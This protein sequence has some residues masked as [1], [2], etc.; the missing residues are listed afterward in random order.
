M[1][2]HNSEECDPYKLCAVIDRAYRQTVSPYFPSVRSFF[3]FAANAVKPVRETQRTESDKCGEHV[4]WSSVG[5]RPAI[6]HELILENH[7]PP[8]PGNHAGAN[9]GQP[10]QFV[11]QIGDEISKKHQY[12]HA[13]DQPE[14]E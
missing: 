7:H 14:D 5:L 8:R 6:E 9:V 10:P 11:D 2:A 13:Q 4:A 1:T 3:L 12:G